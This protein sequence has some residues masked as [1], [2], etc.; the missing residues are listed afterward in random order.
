MLQFN[1]TMDLEYRKL[2]INHFSLAESLKKLASEGFTQVDDF[3]FLKH[4]Y[5]TNTNVS[6]ESF[7]DATGYECF[8][9]SIHIDDY[10]SCDYLAQAVLFTR[11]LFE[12]F[13][14][15]GL[16]SSLVCV[17]SMD[18]LGLNIKFYLARINEL[19]LN[20]DL[21]GYDE[22]VLIIDSSEPGW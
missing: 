21:D 2:D 9:N 8:I 19:Y 12:S 6:A 5:K 18:E 16:Q 10:V 4:C 20:E 11:S 1:K 13:N 7:P 17:M 15:L 14:D 22:A 3:V